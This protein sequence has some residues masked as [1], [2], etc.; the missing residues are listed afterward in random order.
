MDATIRSLI[1]L[2]NVRDVSASIAFYRKLGFEVG[3]DHVPLD[4]T[5]AVWVWLRSDRANLMLALAGEPV[6]PEQ[7][8]V[9]FY[10]YCEDVAATRAALEESGVIVGPIQYPFYAPRGEFRLT[11]PDGYALMITHT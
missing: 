8:A 6:V 11:D 7:Q 10:L 9:L 3:G 5:D 4:R 2:A 1:P